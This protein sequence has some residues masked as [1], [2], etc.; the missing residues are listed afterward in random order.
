MLKLLRA[1][2]AALLLVVPMA[3]FGQAVQVPPAQ[4]C[5][6]ATSGLTGMV[7]TLGAIT[8]GSG[9][10]AGV[11][12]V[13]PLTG[14]SGT[15]ATANI[16]VGSGGSVTQVVILNPGVGYV[17]SDTLSAVSGNIG[18]TTG[19]SVP[20]A[21]VAINSAVAGGSV[22]MYIVGTLT[23][24]DTW[25]DAAQTTFNSNPIKLDQNGCAIIFGTGSYR[26]ILWD[27]LG[28]TIWDRPTSVAPVN[29]F[30][31]GPAGG[32]A[33]AITVSD[34]GF[35]STD[36]QAIQFIAAFTNTGHVTLDPGTGPLPILKNGK[37][38]PIPLV[39]GDIIA[40]NL[41]SVTYVATLNSFVING[42]PTITSVI[43]QAGSV[44][45][46]V[47][48][49]G[50]SAGVQLNVTASQAIIPSF[51]GSTQAVLRSNI[52][53]TGNISNSGAN[54]LDTGTVAA[55]TWYYV[56]MIDNGTAPAGLFSLSS[57]APQ[58]PSGYTYALRIGAI[59][60]DGSVAFYRIQQKGQNAQY[61]V[62]SGS[63]TAALPLMSAS[64]GTVGNIN[65]PTYVALSVSNFVPPTAERIRGVAF[66]S[67]G[68]V[69]V[70]PNSSYGGIASPYANLPPVI[71]NPASNVNSVPFDLMLE[72]T[73]LYYAM[74]CIYTN[75]CN[76]SAIGW[77]DAVP[78]N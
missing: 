43:P 52:S 31:A 68:G 76:V 44:N 6:S 20:V 62:V 7:G 34:P 67:A 75:G 28:N 70:A 55:S 24:K 71:V 32:T 40:G 26:Q 17:V 65:T 18:G 69:I 16:T 66:S 13:V 36:G 50:T 10:V 64:S 41:V 49:N 37:T 23:P 60:T 42:Q 3:A 77:Q 12:T 56:W 5:F 14:G 53:F 61:T 45:S 2:C 46:L 47:I 39:A 59:R 35:T 21:S 78:A 1:L 51:D 38:G 58:L 22:G 54:G 33:N 48:V 19:F 11:Y 4:V 9:G 29:P 15:G 27:S 30:Y 72:S 74:G 8:G 25:Q 57:T 63:N 73:S